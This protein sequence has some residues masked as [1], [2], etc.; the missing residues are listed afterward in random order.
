ME[1][2]I[3]VLKRDVILREKEAKDALQRYVEALNRASSETILM[4]QWEALGK[5]KAYE[6]MW[7]IT[8]GKVIQ[9]YRDYTSTL[10]SR[11]NRR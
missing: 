3:E 4:R 8:V 11:I 1:E 10:E 9:A 5:V 6:Q 7:I 2:N